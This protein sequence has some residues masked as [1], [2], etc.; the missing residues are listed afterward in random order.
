MRKETE[1]LVIGGGPAGL[2]AAIAAARMGAKVVLLEKNKMLG[3]KLRITGKGRCNITNTGDIPAFISQFGEQGP[4]LYSAF[5]R[6]FHE[7]ICRLLTEEGVELK[8]ERGGRVFPASD[9]AADVAA[10]LENA[11]Q[12]AGVE[13]RKGCKV[14]GLLLEELSQGTADDLPSDPAAVSPPDRKS[15]KGQGKQKEKPSYRVKGVRLYDAWD[16]LEIRAQ[17]VILATGGKSYPLTGSTGEGYGWA[18]GA[19]HRIVEPRPA[20]VPLE[21]STGWVAALSGL[22]L[23]NV[24]A[25][26][27]ASESGPE[28]GAECGSE[29][30][31]Q[32]S[33]QCSS[34]SPG[35]PRLLASFQGEM[36]FAHFGL[37]GPIILSLSRYYRQEMAGSAKV[38]IDLKPALSHEVL[39]KRLQR[40]FLQYQ[41]KQLV[42]AMTDLLPRALIP[43]VI[44]EAGLEET[45]PVAELTKEQRLALGKVLKALPVAI[46][47]TRPMEEAI[48]TAGGVALAEVQPKTMASKKAAGLYL[49]GEILDIDGFTGGYN[50]QAAFSTGWVAG[51]SAAFSLAP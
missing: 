33:S 16:D 19:G 30:S 24:K 32:Y 37:T 10:A 7:D 39:D 43:V 5:S 45:Q 26:L 41:K 3:R 36:L 50:L 13:I 28:A 6:F 25:S 44:A 48:V 1:V 29:C 8:T 38:L 11:A 17:A 22:T 20:L 27:W 35:N 42:N 40:D 47:G 2:L 51:E 15:K 31:F 9:Q 12:K 21:S 18:Q 46:T 4:F 23:K 49:A 34:D 14:Q